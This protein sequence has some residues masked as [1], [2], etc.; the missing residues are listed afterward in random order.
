MCE[1]VLS[2]PGMIPNFQPKLKMIS[3]RQ[4]RV[5]F[6]EDTWY[7]AT[8]IR[9]ADL[10]VSWTNASLCLFLAASQLL[11]KSTTEHGCLIIG[12]GPTIN[13]ERI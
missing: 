12:N 4:A 13:D 10:V 7:A 1:G 9:L 8:S 6:F 2:R 3:H 11:S 5:S